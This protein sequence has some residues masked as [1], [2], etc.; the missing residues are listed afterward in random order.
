MTTKGM[1]REF[2]KPHGNGNWSPWRSLQT[3]GVCLYRRFI[4]NSSEE[5]GSSSLYRLMIGL[6]RI[7]FLQSPA[8]GIVLER[9]KPGWP[10]ANEDYFQMPP[11]LI[12]T[13]RARRGPPQAQAYPHPCC[14]QRGRE[15]P[16]SERHSRHEPC[17]RGGRDKSAARLEVRSASRRNDPV[18]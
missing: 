11:V 15:K 4:R 18:H 2:I 12:P 5:K 17:T 3:E 7:R 10:C 14:R 9:T 13:I 8:F 1:R 16:H 6:R